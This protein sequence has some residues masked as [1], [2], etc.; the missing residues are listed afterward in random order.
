MFVRSIV[1]I[2]VVIG[3]A[4]VTTSCKKDEATKSG[5][6]GHVSKVDGSGAGALVRLYPAPDPTDDV[7]VWSVPDGQ[8]A[9]GFTYDLDFAYDHRV[10]SSLRADTADGNG[11]FQFEDVVAGDYVVVA[12]FPGGAWAPY[13][14]I[15][16]G[17][18]D[19]QVGDFSIPLVVVYS[20]ENNNVNINQNTTWES[21]T[22]Y[23]LNDNTFVQTG[24]TLTIEPGA[25][26]RLA[27]NKSLN[28][29]N[30]ATLVCNGTPDNFIIF[31]SSEVINRD[32]DEW[33]QVKFFTDAAPPNI[34]YTEFRYGASGV[35][36]DVDS[37]LVEYCHFTR[38]VNEGVLALRQPPI[39]RRCVFDRAATG[40]RAASTGQFL[41]ERN[42]F[43]T[44]DPFAIILDTVHDG[45]IT[46]N[47]FR[48]CGGSDTSG[49]GS[50]GVI[51]MDLVSTTEIHH[52]YFETSSNA[53]QLGSWVDSTVEIHHNT[54][55]QIAR[56]LNIQTTE[57]R[58]GPSNPEVH[59]NCFNSVWDFVVFV[60]CSQHTYLDMDASQNWWGTL[61]MSFIQS[62]FVHDQFDDDRCPTV[63]VDPV[64]N[65][66]SQI[67][68]LSGSPAGLCQ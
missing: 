50:R 63:T 38:F 16:T 68:S 62:E 22:H 47:W 19:V 59:F 26:V 49:A 34:T 11:D 30:G 5:V 1:L 61:S 65:S 64:V 28:V 55:D 3:L 21:G 31:T 24:V 42:V 39:V 18:G 17:G 25:V 52:N 4:L 48:D 66:C 29:R 43:Q 60:H 67:S 36:S 13:K 7:S 51:R 37:G 41:F 53:F 9:V 44:C 15:S 8:P 6:T 57:E 27:G 14:L 45:E 58:R 56:A 20:L 40:V 46:C 12:E 10:I 23:V 2:A 32:P 54:F 33:L 35:V